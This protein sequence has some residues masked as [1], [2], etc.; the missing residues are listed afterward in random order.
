MNASSVSAVSC[1]KD[2]QTVEAEPRNPTKSTTCYWPGITNSALN[3]QHSRCY[4]SLTQQNWYFESAAISPSKT[5]YCLCKVHLV[6]ISLNSP[7]DM[8]YKVLL[9]FPACYPARCATLSITAEKL[10]KPS[11]PSRVVTANTCHTAFSLRTHLPR[12]RYVRCQSVHVN[13]SP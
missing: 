11:E 4:M 2:L 7:L 1:S 13:H 10:D 8:S 9:K 5:R 3:T 12:S 6:A